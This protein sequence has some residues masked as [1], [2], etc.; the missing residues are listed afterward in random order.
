MNIIQK[1]TAV[2][3][4]ENKLTLFLQKY[5][6]DIFNYFINQNQA[7]LITIAPKIDFYLSGNF[8]IIKNIDLT[9]NENHIFIDILIDV[10]ER[11][12]LSIYFQRLCRIKE[13]SG[14]SINNRNQASAL[15]INNLRHLDD[16]A[17][18]LN[19]LL[20]KLQFAYQY[21]EDTDKRV[22]AVFF[23]FYANIIQNFGEFNPQGVNLIIGEIKACRNNFSFLTSILADTI[24]EIDFIDPHIAFSL[25]HL[26][27]DDYLDRKHDEL[28]YENERFL[29]ES[30][31]KY[32]NLL[33]EIPNDIFQIRGLSSNL[34]DGD[35]ETFYSLGR[36]VTI[37]SKEQQLYAYLHSYGNMHIAKSIYAYTKLPKYFFSHDIEIIDWGCGQALASITYLDYLSKNKI[38]QRIKLISLNE[39]SQIALKRG[40]LHIKKYNKNIDIVTIN[41][42][43]NSLSTNDFKDIDYVKLHLF[44]NILDIDKYSIKYLSSL[45]K[46]THKGLNYFVITSPKITS[47][48]TNRIDNFVREFYNCN[49]KLLVSEEK[50][51]GE[52]EGN[53]TKVLRIFEVTIV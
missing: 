28:L 39:P 20:I 4:D 36:G 21:E 44:S 42:E 23:N 9:I 43:L 14:F 13:K 51:A 19:E 48:K 49:Y 32:T 46:D 5:S 18:I 10:S 33:S 26:A 50:D 35:K 30:G 38:Q 37:L 31:T 17:K 47:L 45:I 34:F 29:I 2:S 8:K 1:L 11:L 40:S 41:K 24:F 12:N 27:I 6:D 25:I 7:D 53:W 16:F 52:W 15:Y 22:L 3:D